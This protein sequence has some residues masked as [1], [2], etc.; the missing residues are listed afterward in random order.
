MSKNTKKKGTTETGERIVSENRRARHD[1]EIL[2]SLECGIVLAGSEVKSLRAGTITLTESYGRIRNNEVWLIN[3]DIPEYFDANRFNHKR[4]RDRKL[5]LHRREINRFAKKV[6]EKGI[7]LVPLRL[8]FRN[9][10]AK[11][12]LG[13]CKGKQDYDKRESKK[14]ADTARGLR[15]FTM[16]RR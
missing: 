12:L 16:R 13:L 2:D 7:T 3:C 5:L 15:Q 10:K 8:Y 4:R 14:Q 6:T 11:L 9:G 1:Y